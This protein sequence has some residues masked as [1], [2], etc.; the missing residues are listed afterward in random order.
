MDSTDARRGQLQR[1]EGYREKRERKPT[2][3]RSPLLAR[4]PLF[5]LNAPK[6]QRGRNGAGRLRDGHADEGGKKKNPVV[7]RPTY[8]GPRIA[9]PDSDHGLVRLPESRK[10]CSSYPQRNFV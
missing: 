7:K 9:S 4:G 3:H 5:F 2:G 10:V 6:R 8:S 1:S